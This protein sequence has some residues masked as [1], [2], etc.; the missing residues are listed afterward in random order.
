TIY[1][2]GL[3]IIAI[4]FAGV[5]LIKETYLFFITSPLLGFG[6]G[7]MMTNITAWMLSK[8]SIKKRVKTSGYFTSAIFLGQFS[9]PI[10][11]HPLVSF[12]GVQSFFFTIGI[13]LF[14]IIVF[15][16]LYIKIK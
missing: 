14:V 15:S 11:F 5:G 4:G 16:L 6:G 8:T 7:I 3:F 9:S 1:L 12:L 2:I 13:S 10:V